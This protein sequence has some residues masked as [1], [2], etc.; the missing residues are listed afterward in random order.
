MWFGEPLLFRAMA[1]LHAGARPDGYDMILHPMGF[2]AWFGMLATA[3]NLLPFGQL[4][5]GHIVYAVFGRASSA[6][7]ALTLAATLALTFWSPSW[8]AMAVLMLAM[9]FFVGVRHPTV[10]DDDEPLG[11]GRRVVALVALIMFVLC[12]TP[13]PIELAN[14]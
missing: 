6:I 4:D 3:L 11:A 2:A 8:F 1:Y 7:S 12:F 14:F 9:A 13:V 10:A 5:G